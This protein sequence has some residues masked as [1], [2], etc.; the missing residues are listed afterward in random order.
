MTHTRFHSALVALVALVTVTVL[1]VIALVA[2][3]TVTGTGAGT[4]ATGHEAGTRTVPLCQSE[5]DPNPGV[6]GCIWDADNQGNGEGR[7][8]FV[9]ADGNVSY[10][11]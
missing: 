1:A 6:T 2:L 10:I 11:G 9:G 3:V 5:A 8:Y 7:S 4:K